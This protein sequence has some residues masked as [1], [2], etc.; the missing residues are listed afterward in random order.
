MY[1]Y[2]HVCRGQNLTSNVFVNISPLDFA[3]TKSYIKVGQLASEICLE[4]GL[5][6][7]VICETENGDSGDDLPPSHHL[8]LGKD[9][10]TV[11][12]VYLIS[13]LKMRMI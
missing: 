1:I 10:Q 13:F 7:K 9:W 8:S 4:S 6:Y 5:E 12:Q 2:L 3:K 11:L